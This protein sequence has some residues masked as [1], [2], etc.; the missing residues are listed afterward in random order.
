M[1]LVI[2]AAYAGWLPVV[3]INGQGGTLLRT[4]W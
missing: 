4:L 3:F 2:W 1:G